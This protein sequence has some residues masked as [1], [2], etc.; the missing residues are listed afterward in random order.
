MAD[1]KIPRRYYLQKRLFERARDTGMDSIWRAKQEAETPS[2]ALPA[3]FPHAA[4]LSPFY[5]TVEDL[6][7]ADAT[8][9]T[10][11]GLTSREATAVLAALAALL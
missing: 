6:D 3:G 5:L 11:F 7:G 1:L 4:T 8:E 9:L 10:D 2:T